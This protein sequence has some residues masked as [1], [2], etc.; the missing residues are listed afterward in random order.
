MLEKFDV[1]QCKNLTR[2]LEGGGEERS[3]RRY[4]RRGLVFEVSKKE[5]TLR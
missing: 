5:G 2:W 1:S 3:R 4:G